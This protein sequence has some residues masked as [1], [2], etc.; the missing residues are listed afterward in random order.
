MGEVRHHLHELFNHKIITESNSPYT[1]PIVIMR[2]KNGSLW[3]CIDYRVLNAL[4]VVDQYTGPQVQEA[5]D[6]LGGSKWFTML[7][8]CGGYYQ[9]LLREADKEKTAFI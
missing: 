5:L 1:S 9:I 7:D 6:Y 2:K 4:T 8:L 3:M